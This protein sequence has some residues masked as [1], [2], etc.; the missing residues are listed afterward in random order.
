ML[1][2]VSRFALETLP[3]SLSMLSQLRPKTLDLLNRYSPSLGIKQTFFTMFIRS[4]L[5]QLG[6]M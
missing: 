2:G 3:K 5:P 4:V 6:L 1:A